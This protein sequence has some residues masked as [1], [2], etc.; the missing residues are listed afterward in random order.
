[1]N[2][3][4]AQTQLVLASASPRRLALLQSMGLRVVQR[5]VDVDETPRAQE[6]AAALVHRLAA[7]KARAGRRLAIA[8]LPALGAD[9]VVVLDGR[10][11]GKPRDR[12]DA[13]A[14][15]AALSGR[16]HEVLSGVA[17]A[18][19]P[20]DVQVRISRSTVHFREIP[21]A[22]AAR[23]WESGEPRDKAG[24]Y[25]IQGIGGVFVERLDGSFSGVMGL[26]V[27][28]TEQLLRAAGVDCWR[29]RAD[30]G[31]EEVIS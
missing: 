6:S 19:T 2:E 29:H 12:R 20:D 26:P 23:Y 31:A 17:V 13:L 27:A 25:G 3:I 21:A 15:L 5:A 1:M 16:V 28:E 4:D 10:I 9:T 24:A 18:T 7:A 8:E 11:L 30:P 22:E 14:M